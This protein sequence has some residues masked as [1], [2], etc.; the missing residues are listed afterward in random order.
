MAKKVTTLFIRDDSIN[1]L[2]MRGEKVEKWAIMPLEPGLVSQGLIVDEAQVVEKLKELFK[3]QKLGMGRVIAGISG[4]NSVYRIITLP[5]LPEAVL[6]EAVK[7]E[8]KRVIPVPLEE[9]YLSYQPITT[10]AG[11]ALVFLA[12]FPRNIAD[13]LYQTL[14]KAGLQPYMMDLA[15]LALCRAANQ[16]RSLIVNS[17]ADHLDIMVIVDR[18]P[19]LIRRLSMP[20]E[21][22]SP[23]ERL[24]T[25]TEEID[26]TIAFY[27]SSHG[28]EPLDTAVPMLVCGDLARAPENW[29]ALAEKSTHPVSVMPSPV[30]TPAGFDANEFMVNIGL[31]LKELSPEKRENNFS[32]VN[33]NTLP[34]VYRPKAVRLPSILA[35][36]AITIGVGILVYLGIM[37]VNKANYIGVLEDEL[38][39]LEILVAS[40]NNAISA[41]EEDIALIEPQIAVLET[42]AGIFDG[43]YDT[44]FEARDKMNED[45]SQ[46]V[47]LQP[48]NL[49]TAVDHTGDM[50]MLTGYAT[51]EGSI[52]NYARALRNSGRFSTVVITAIEAVEDDDIIVGLNF[53]F[54]LR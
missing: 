32:L 43:T 3:L 19:Q 46:I 39:P 17:R 24:D 20:G 10:A 13:T 28:E 49:L 52:F 29:Q 35:P 47:S 42:A 22:E 1:L 50:V 9:V 26:R 48:G 14:H 40:E 31:G 12:A 6:P 54:L 30:E 8:A 21:A 45:M 27:N 18:V 5:E 23:A 53:E 51:N 25:V 15:P 38:T 37:I 33:I 7:R 34:E 11:E 41:L 2:V 4:H 36:I 44:L 16:P